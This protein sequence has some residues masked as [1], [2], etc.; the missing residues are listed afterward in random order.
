VEVQ[1]TPHV[2]AATEIL[3]GQEPWR[4]LG[5]NPALIKERLTRYLRQDDKDEA[6]GLLRREPI[7]ITLAE[8]TKGI[9]QVRHAG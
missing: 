3:A 7:K 6:W 4:G 5:Y 8:F 9:W 2:E 1:A